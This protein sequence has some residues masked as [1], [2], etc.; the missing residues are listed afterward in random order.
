MSYELADG[1][2]STDYKEGDLFVYNDPKGQDNGTFRNGSVI[3]F[4]R[5]DRSDCP[6]FSLVQGDCFGDTKDLCDAETAYAMWK[7]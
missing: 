7:N 5:D 6:L 4:L 1:S 2:L 3:K